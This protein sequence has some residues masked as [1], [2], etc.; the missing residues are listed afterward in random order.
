MYGKATFI[1]VNQLRHD[2]FFSEISRYIIPGTHCS[3]WHSFPP[4]K[5]LVFLLLAECHL[6]HIFKKSQLLGIHIS[7]R[8]FQAMNGNIGKLIMNHQF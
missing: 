7:F 4:C 2:S 8:M 6:K 1:R 3:Y 5:A